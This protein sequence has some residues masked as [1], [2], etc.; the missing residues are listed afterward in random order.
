M[1]GSDV[2]NDSDAGD[3]IGAPDES[4]A[5]DA[6]GDETCCQCHKTVL[7]CH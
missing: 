5:S 6:N 7:H 2:V 4:D 3:D 1:K